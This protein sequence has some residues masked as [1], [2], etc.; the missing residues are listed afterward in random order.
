[1]PHTILV[2]ILYIMSAQT[3]CIFC[4]I[5]RGQVE[6]NR[7]WEDEHTLV[8][9]DRRPLFP[10]H[11]L[12]VPKQHV[13]ELADLPNSLIDPMFGTVQMIS[14][15]VKQALE[16][17]GTFVA[18]NNNVSQ[19]VPHLHVHIVPRNKGD[20]LKGFFW[21][22]NPYRDQAHADEVAQRLIEII[23]KIKLP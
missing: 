18:I 20:G 16:C 13:K 12:L 21:P 4:D 6:A 23:E 1:M 19:S 11:C 7:I 5:I 17:Q 22:R 8:F 9:L 15:V 10:G 14:Q 3:R 2:W